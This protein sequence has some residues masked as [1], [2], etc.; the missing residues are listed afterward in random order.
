MVSLTQNGYV[1]RG[2]VCYGVW[3]YLNKYR[4]A[5]R[6]HGNYQRFEAETKKE[7]QELVKTYIQQ[8]R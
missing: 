1:Y 2:K 4:A 5:V 3:E 8:N 7:L 6:V